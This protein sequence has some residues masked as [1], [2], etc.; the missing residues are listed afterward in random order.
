MCL[1]G[2]TEALHLH[3]GQTDCSMKSVCCIF[4]GKKKKILP[5]SSTNMF[6]AVRPITLCIPTEWIYMCICVCVG[7]SDLIGLHPAGGLLYEIKLDEGE[8]S[9]LT[10]TPPSAMATEQQ[11]HNNN[12]VLGLVLHVQRRERPCI[13]TR[14]TSL[15]LLSFFS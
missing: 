15:H 6:C 7:E 2:F 11:Q 12:A 14:R 13:S 9:A 5:T 1:P 8:S 3:L 4:A 10:W